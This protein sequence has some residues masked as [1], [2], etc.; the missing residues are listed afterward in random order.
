MQNLKDKEIKLKLLLRAHEAYRRAEKL[1][2]QVK[3]FLMVYVPVSGF[4][5]TDFNVN[6]AKYILS[7][8][9]E[10]EEEM[11]FLNYVFEHYASDQNKDGQTGEIS[12]VD[13]SWS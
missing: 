7:L 3:Y 1:H 5:V 11:E 4:Y 6:M 12:S 10:A 2:K 13:S 9:E 8:S